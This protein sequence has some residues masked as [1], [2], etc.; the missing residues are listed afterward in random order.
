LGYKPETV[1]AAISRLN[2]NYFLPAIQREFVWAPEK[3]I[4]LF[5]SLMRGYPISSFLFWEVKPDNRDKWQVYRFVENASGEGTHNELANTDGVQQLTLVLDGQQRLTSVL[6]GLKGTY[7]IKKKYKKKA[8]PDAWSK[9]R[10]YLNLL[11]DPKFEEEDD[12]RGVRYGFA[13]FDGEPSNDAQHCWLK[14][15]RILDF[16]NDD[17][18]DDFKAQ[19]EDKLPGN[20]TKDQVKVFRANLDR[21]H[22]AIWK[23]QPIAYHTEL[24]QDYDRVLDI[25]VRAND[26]G[27]K[28]DKSDLLLST[29]IAEW[30]DLNARDEIYGFVDLLNTKLARKNAFDKDFLMKTCLVLS[31]LSVEY[32][33]RNFKSPNLKLI[34]S[35]WEGIKDAIQKGVSLVNSFG[36]DRDTLISANALIPVIYYLYTQPKLTLGGTTAFDVQCTYAIR[37][38]LTTSL[39]RGAFGVHSDTALRAAREALGKLK[40]GDAFPLAELNAEMSKRGRTGAFDSDTITE[41]LSL[42][43]G[44]PRTFLAL[45]LL[46]DDNNWANDPH[47]DHIFPRQLFSKKS[48]NDRGLDAG[49]QARYAELMD[50]LGNLQLL[51]QKENNQK[52]GQE[53]EKWIN[54]RDES[55]LDR[56]LIP[57][58]QALWRFESFER[59][60]EAREKLIRDRLASLLGAPTASG[61]EADGAAMDVEGTESSI[62]E[63]PTNHGDSGFGLDGA[64]EPSAE[65]TG[66]N[67]DELSVGGSGSEETGTLA[68]GTE[69]PVDGAELKAGAEP[70]AS[71]GDS[72]NVLAADQLAALRERYASHVSTRVII[73]HFGNRERNQNVT[74]LDALESAL[75]RDRTPLPYNEIL[76]VMRRFDQLGLG[77]FIPG[78]KGR[79]TRFEWRVESRLVHGLTTPHPPELP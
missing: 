59:F 6:I 49:K 76:D 38:W 73:D 50:R 24:D 18:F 22:R 61:D 58:D 29:V 40:A 4:Q 33:I 79:P 52:S 48:M 78:R 72:T 62:D 39:L 65:G 46:Y 56:H 51:V 5:D 8:S 71:A 64:P 44:K 77:R 32:K 45:T 7:T 23:E 55:F 60:I 41:T 69:T 36:I 30:G 3:V 54:S 43:Y 9:Q 42:T 35:K 75:Q 16:D 67:R 31:D 21:L 26:G 34:R 15:G 13:F 19:F 25:F 74:K 68:K 10:L 66:E 70:L 12:D 14:V 11:K 57:R 47:E 63:V 53:F 20:T 1:A 37:V 2:F 28:L 27:V 17:A